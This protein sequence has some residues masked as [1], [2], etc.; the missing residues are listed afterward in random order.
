M[1]SDPADAVFSVEHLGLRI[2]LYRSP[3]DAAVVVDIETDPEVIPVRTGDRSSNNGP[4]CRVYLNDHKLHGLGPLGPDPTASRQLLAGVLGR[5]VGAEFEA[6]TAGQL[7]VD[8]AREVRGHGVTVR[9]HTSSIDALPV[10]EIDTDD[11]VDENDR[12]PVCRISL[13]DQLVNDN[14]YDDEI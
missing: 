8:D 1:I 3:N 9:A 13:D 10:V 2:G 6:D 12:G 4:L 7:I 11:S 5:Q 14:W